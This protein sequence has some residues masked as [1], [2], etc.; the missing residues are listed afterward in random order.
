MNNS[1]MYLDV[2]QRLDF[3]TAH[4][5]GRNYEQSCRAI[6][7]LEGK[8]AKLVGNDRASLVTLWK[9]VLQR[10]LA[11]A[12]ST[13]QPIAE[14]ERLLELYNALSDSYSVSDIGVVVMLYRYYLRQRKRA[15]ADALIEGAF[16]AIHRSMQSQ[17]EVR[18]LLK[19][20]IAEL[21][22]S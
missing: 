21:L 22:S 6:N 5:G 8:A 18:R 2:I 20:R 16:A 9:S 3:I 14:C 1:K 4:A 10:K 11:I 17:R 15:R 12:I 13:D 19:R 7:R